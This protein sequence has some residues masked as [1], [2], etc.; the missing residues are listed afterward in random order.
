MRR[1]ILIGAIAIT[2]CAAT[3][4]DLG[5]KNVRMSLTKISH[6]KLSEYYQYTGYFEIL[7]QGGSPLCIMDDIFSNDLSPYVKI[8][9]SLN[10]ND[11]SDVI[12]NPPKSDVIYR[13]APGERKVFRKIIEYS[14]ADDGIN[15]GY[16]VSLEMSYCDEAGRRF[17]KS[18][19]LNDGI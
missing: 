5:K 1:L 9:N 10:S 15:K 19:V 12:P 4:N 16:I 13:I 3:M 7:N 14:K 11:Y 18:V 8:R 6:E 2:G 17:S